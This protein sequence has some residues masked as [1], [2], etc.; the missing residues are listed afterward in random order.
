MSNKITLFIDIDGVL[1]TTKQHLTNQKI[2]NPENIS[3]SFDEKCVK[4]FNEI[5]DV[6]K[7]IVILSSDWKNKHNL[8]V[9]NH[10]FQLNNV[11]CIIR[12]MTPNHWNTDFIKIRSIE[13]CRAIEIMSYVKTYNVDKFIVIDDFDLSRWFETNFIHTLMKT[14]GIKQVGIKE[15]ILRLHQNIINNN[16]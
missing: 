8:G 16:Y 9:M 2:W 3:Y 4:V 1:V 10:I 12:D 7:P 5:L 13:E 6:I 15:K 11:E 14:K